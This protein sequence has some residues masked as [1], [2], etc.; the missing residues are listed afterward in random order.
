MDLYIIRHAQSTNNA[1]D[2]PRNRSCDP[3]L[4]ELGL[5]QAEILAGHLAASPH[6]DGDGPTIRL[7]CSPMWRALQTAHVM[8]RALGLS[9]EVWVDIHEIGGIYLD[10]GEA[11]G[12]VGYPGATRH[13]I[14]ADFPSVALPTQVTGEGWWQGGYEDWPACHRRAA[15]VAEA[16]RDQSGR[17]ERVL[18][19]T[20]GGFINALMNILVGQ[21]PDSPVVYHQRNTAIS[22]ISFGDNGRL[23]IHYLNRASHLAPDMVS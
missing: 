22:L 19:V 11:G 14:L 17:Q 5:R 7:Y 1:L 12:L 2:D 6:L 16:L 21:S 10:H 3:R 18:M 15:R 13:Q 20:H 4:T 9:P 8:G 23:H